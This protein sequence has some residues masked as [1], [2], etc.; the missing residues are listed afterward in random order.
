MDLYSAS[1]KSALISASQLIQPG[2][3][4]TLRNH[5]YGLVYHAICLFTLP[6]YARYAFYL[7]TEGRLRLSRPGCLVPR[8]GSLSVQTLNRGAGCAPAR[9]QLYWFQRLA[10]VLLVIVLL[11]SQEHVCGTAYQPH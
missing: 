10:A 8:R 2:N 11:Q 1:R 6:A 3:Q 9:H 7:A 4:R 5:G